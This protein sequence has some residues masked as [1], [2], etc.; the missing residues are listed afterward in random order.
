MYLARPFASTMPAAICAGH[1]PRV[2]M[3][4]W[5]RTAPVLVGKTSPASLCGQRNR[6]SLNVLVNIGGIG[7]VRWPEDDFGEPMV[8]NLSA[9]CVTRS[10]PACRSRLTHG[11]PRKRRE[12][13]GR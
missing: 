2:R 11:K 12:R 8:L 1:K 3:L 13:W 10:T 5:S 4:A 9:R 6:H 7:T